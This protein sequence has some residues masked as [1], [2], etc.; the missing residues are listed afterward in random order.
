M[1]DKQKH[2]QHQLQTLNPNNDTS[3]IHA[4]QQEQK[5]IPNIQI[6]GAMIRSRCKYWPEDET[7]PESFIHYE[8]Q[9][10]Q[11]RQVKQFDTA[12]N[13]HIIDYFTK[14]WT[15]LSPTTHTHTHKPI[16]KI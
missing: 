10:Q 7:P 13:T 8:K 6:R 14:I 9:K 4:L 12:M 1:I 16:Y 15:T 2:I 3:E 11:N 5:R